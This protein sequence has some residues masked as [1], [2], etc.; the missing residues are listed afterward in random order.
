MIPTMDD[1]LEE[2]DGLSVRVKWAPLPPEMDGAFLL[3]R[4][5]IILSD[6]LADY[7]QRPALAHEIEH[8]RRGDD[9]PQPPR[10]EQHID[11]IVACR[12]VDFMAYAR[13]ETERGWNTPAIARDLDL[14]RWVIQ[15]YRRALEKAV[16]K[17]SA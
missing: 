2:C 11:E 13:S 7:Q 4:R 16:R 10:V 12:F 9:G 14:P 6:D 15:A 17:V 5:T 1:L 8:A 3:P